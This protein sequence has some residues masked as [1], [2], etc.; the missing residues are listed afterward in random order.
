MVREMVSAGDQFDRTHWEFIRFLRNNPKTRT[1][2]I[3]QHEIHQSEHYAY[4]STNWWKFRICLLD[5]VPAGYVR[6]DKRDIAVCVH[7]EFQR[8]GIGS[9]M[10]RFI[11]K[12][13]PTAFAKIKLDN[14]ASI[15]LFEK[16]GFKKKYYILEQE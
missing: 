6:V 9:F 11:K 16:N 7:P 2:F 5:G 4:M 13:N 1:G 10:I 12:H 8:N 14:A 3:Q 15:N